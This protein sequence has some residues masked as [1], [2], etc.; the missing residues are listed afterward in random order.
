MEDFA[1]PSKIT[2]TI[3]SGT[4]FLVLAAEDS[5]WGWDVFQLFQQK[6]RNTDSLGGRQLFCRRSPAE[7]HLAFPVWVGVSLQE[8]VRAS[9]FLQEIIQN[10]DN[11]IRD[12]IV[13]PSWMVL[14]KCHG[15]TLPT[16][17]RVWNPMFFIIV[18][19]P[20][21]SM[22]YPWPLYTPFSSPARLP[23]FK[24]TNCMGN[25]FCIHSCCYH[26]HW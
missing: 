13:S 1:I 20:G 26:L 6:N 25:I 4:C 15:H 22:C 16:N 3:F 2:S 17:S 14:K 11:P 9:F 8:L 19:L 18:P 7:H 23:T 5:H 21:I 24:C 10:S 12:I